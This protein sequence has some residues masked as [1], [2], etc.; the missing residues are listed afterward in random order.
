MTS[1]F[2]ANTDTKVEISPELGGAILA[3]DVKLHNQFV[4]ILRNSN[5]ANSVL[6]SSCFPLVPYSNRIKHGHF[7]W[8]EKSIRLPLNHLPEKHSIHGHGW[9]LPWEVTQ[10][11]D[12][13]LTIQY[14]Y[15]TAEWPF[16]YSAKQVFTL[17]ESSLNIE[18]SI[19]NTSN[20]QMPGGLGL[21]PYF[22]L[23]NKT[24]IKCSV[25]KMW[26]VDDECLP[27]IL[28]D[29]PKALI[30][31]KGLPILDSNL[32]N[33][34][35]GFTKAATLTWPEWQA[36]AKITTSSNCN[37]MVIYSPQGKNYFCFEPVT[38]C[39]DAINMS[40]KGVKNTGV[41]TLS[42]QQRMTMSMLISP[43]EI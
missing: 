35:T 2:L 22:S 32:D 29:A 37:F 7:N 9:Q 17:K 21:H 42:P 10:Q 8:Q 36:K 11:T 6:E 25:A 33:V 15:Q 23:T 27:T 4:P 13:S 12:S 41:I 30:S 38:H 20:S 34:F 14:H 1:L 19:I 16:S 43:E 18:L 26:A 24:S 28:V 5:K 3:Y 31:S 40:D 39:T